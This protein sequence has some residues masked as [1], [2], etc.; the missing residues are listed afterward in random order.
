M[1]ND[2]SFTRGGKIF[3]G[4]IKDTKQPWVRHREDTPERF[5]KGIKETSAL[6]LDSSTQTTLPP[7]QNTLA[8]S[9]QG[10]PVGAPQTPSGGQANPS[11]AQ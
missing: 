4:N 9:N 2:P 10:G 1:Q 6:L 3:R 11:S 5:N 8:G 7:A